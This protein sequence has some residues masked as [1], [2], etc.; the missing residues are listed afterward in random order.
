MIVA[1]PA[2]FLARVMRTALVFAAGLL[3]SLQTGTHVA[4]AGSPLLTEVEVHSFILGRA[5]KASVYLPDGYGAEPNSLRRYPVIYLLHGLGDDH[6]AWVKLAQI[7]QTL[8]RL[9]ASGELQPV[10]LVMPGASRSWYVNDDR[11]DGFG[12]VADA[13]RS[14]LIESVDARYRT[15]ACRGGR[16]IGGLSMGGYGALLYGFTRPDLYTA[17]F[18]LSGAVF[19]EQLSDN[20]PGRAELEKLFGGL[21]GDPFDEAQFAEWNIFDRL[22]AIR[23]GETY[24][25]TWLSAGDDDYFADIVTGTA[26]VH[27]ILQ[28][29]GVTSEL[30]IDDATHDWSYWQRSIV[31]ALRW[32]SPRLTENCR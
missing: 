12:R 22:Q 32:I 30:R 19:P 26:R 21:F 28:S 20:H 23:S 15:A 8:D 6:T 13:F 24:P 7:K 25:A 9:I 17:V 16:A 4:N 3:G 2:M 11:P 10:I 27:Q 18:S 31:P 14:E 5:I 1:W 29:K